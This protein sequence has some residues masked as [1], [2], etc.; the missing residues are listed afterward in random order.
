MSTDITGWFKS[1]YS[2]DGDK[3]VEVTPVLMPIGIVPVRDSKDT[4]KEPLR[5]RVDAYTAFIADVKDGVYD[6]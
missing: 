6:L 5:F 3:C 4:S 1:S 2:D